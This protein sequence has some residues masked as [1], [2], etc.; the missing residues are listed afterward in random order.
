MRTIRW[1]KSPTDP[2]K[3]QSNARILRWSDGSLT[4]QM[5]NDPSTQYS[6]PGHPLA[7]PQHNPRK[8][9]PTSTGEGRRK[10]PHGQRN[11]VYNTDQDAFTYLATPSVGSGLLRI[12]NKITTSLQV[13]LTKGVADDAVSR[14]QTRINTT[15]AGGQNGATAGIEMVEHTVDPELKRKQAEQTEKLMLKERRNRDLAELREREHTKRAGAIVSDYELKASA[16]SR[17]TSAGGRKAKAKRQRRDEIYSDE[18]ENWGKRGRTKED[19]Y[20]ADDGFMVSDEDEEEEEEEAEASDE[21]QDIDEG[22]DLSNP[23]LGKDGSSPGADIAKR[24]V[25]NEG[26][27]PVEGSPVA[28]SKRRRVIEEDEDE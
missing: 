7:P 23:S 4:L 6:V 17:R 21:D 3:L 27:A 26:A 10:Q 28:R 11:G 22:I 8:P 9:T 16:G 5:A 15:K 19:E 25:E 2:S 12:T 1:R 14:L 20:E 13:E 18:E 24:T